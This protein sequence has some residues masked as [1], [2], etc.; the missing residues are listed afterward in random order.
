MHRDIINDLKKW[1]DKPRRK[2]L[3]LTGVRQCGKTYIIGEFAKECFETGKDVVLAMQ[4]LIGREE[5]APFIVRKE[6]AFP[7]SCCPGEEMQEEK[8]PINKKFITNLNKTYIYLG[9]N[10]TEQN[11]F[12]IIPKNN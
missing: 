2:P 9:E 1:K 4:R 12:L 7:G 11:K 3:L 5:A 8:Y 6:A 10:N